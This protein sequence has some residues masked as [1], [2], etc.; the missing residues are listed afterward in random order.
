ME[1]TLIVAEVQHGFRLETLSGDFQILIRLHGDLQNNLQS[2]SNGSRA[3]L[4]DIKEAYLR[5]NK[6][7]LWEMLLA[8][9]RH[10]RRHHQNPTRPAAKHVVRN[11]REGR[12]QLAM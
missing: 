10:Q 12:K 1:G 7:I 3:L 11:P 2:N 5:V 8:K 9:V 6:I 4:F